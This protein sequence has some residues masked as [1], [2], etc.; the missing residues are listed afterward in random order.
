MQSL[1]VYFE[2]TSKITLNPNFLSIIIIFGG[3]MTIGEFVPLMARVT[4]AH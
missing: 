2:S 1:I 4:E 3:F